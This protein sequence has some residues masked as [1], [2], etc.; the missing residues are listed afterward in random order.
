MN[1]VYYLSEEDVKQLSDIVEI[2]D[3]VCEKAEDAFSKLLDDVIVE[4]YRTNQSIS[5]I[6]LEEYEKALII[7]EDIY[8][9]ARMAVNYMK[10]CLSDKE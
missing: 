10:N 3:T 5:H 8:N 7:V 4:E 6:D 2:S 9:K 1:C